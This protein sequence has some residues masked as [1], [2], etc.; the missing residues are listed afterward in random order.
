[1]KTKLKAFLAIALACICMLAVPAFADATNVV[2]IGQDLSDDQEAFIVKYF[3]ADLSRCQ[4]IYV[5]NQQEREYVGS[6]IPLEQIGN[7]TISSA[8]VQPTTSGGIQVKT[9]NLTYV[10]GNMIASV[11]STAGVKNCNVVAAAPFPVSGT[12]ALTGVMIA[13]QVATGETLDESKRDL[14]V[15]E[16]TV[17]QQAAESIGENEALQ[18]VNAVKMQV[19]QSAVSA[20]DTAQ[21]A[22]I[23]DQV[24]SEVQQGM[25]AENSN[26]ENS[27]LVNENNNY[28]DNSTYNDNSVTNVDESTT[29]YNSGLSDADRQMIIDL[30]TQIA[31]QDYQYE[32]VKETLKRVEENLSN[33]T[34]INISIDN[35]D[36]VAVENN[37]NNE[38]SNNNNND[39]DNNSSASADSNAGTVD[40]S[41][42][43]L[44]NT[45][46]DMIDVIYQSSTREEDIA[47]I[48][49]AIEEQESMDAAAAFDQQTGQIL[50][51]TESA[52]QSDA[53]EW[54]MD[55]V[56]YDPVMPESQA[57]E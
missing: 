50:P 41:E 37:N 43:I 49:E 29:V 9:A 42:N 33:E 38:N 56:V 17:T 45:N 39:N 8:Y 32:E 48:E 55:E 4:V 6:W 36:E 35:S 34:N 12:G 46:D 10:T 21:I 18:L 5:T 13:Y 1:M 19:I 16:F 3:G 24:A 15:K 20:D 52:Q 14:A 26:I 51:E 25:S 22:Q 30:A 57:W 11:L 53:P 23:V 54:V 47:A 28:Y 27:S 44:S 40:E 31:K 7:I 2:T